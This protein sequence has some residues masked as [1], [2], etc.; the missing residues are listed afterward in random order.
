M[1]W[2]RVP[3][4]GDKQAE[5]EPIVRVNKGRKKAWIR[6]VTRGTGKEIMR[7]PGQTECQITGGTLK[8]GPFKSGNECECACVCVREQA[9]LG[10]PRRLVSHLGW[11]R[12]VKP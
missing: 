12:A 6:V 10:T 2:L 7:G 8:R 11:R 5:P 3:K 1:K 4:S 9:P